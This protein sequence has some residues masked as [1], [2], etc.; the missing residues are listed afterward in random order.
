MTARPTVNLLRMLSRVVFAWA[1]LPT[2]TTVQA[3]RLL[4]LS[5]RLEQ[6][7]YELEDLAGIR[8]PPPPINVRNPDGAPS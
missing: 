1:T 5:N 8:K 4:D 2:T 6:V 3:G 7:A